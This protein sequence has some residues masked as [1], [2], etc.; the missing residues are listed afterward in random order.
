MYISKL[1][2]EIALQILYY[3]STAGLQKHTKLLFHFQLK[4]ISLFTVPTAI[5]CFALRHVKVKC[6]GV[7]QFMNYVIKTTI[8]Y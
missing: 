7:I 6:L 4:N 3:E 8:K 5:H 1:F 2:I